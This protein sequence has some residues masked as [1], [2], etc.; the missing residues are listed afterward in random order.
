MLTIRCG[1]I[2]ER[3]LPISDYHRRELG[4]THVNHRLSTESAVGDSLFGVNRKSHEHA[5]LRGWIQPDT[6]EIAE[7]AQT[8]LVEELRRE[9][10]VVEEIQAG[11]MLHQ[12]ETPRHVDNAYK[13]VFREYLTKL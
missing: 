3:P 2:Q 11:V 12:R 4:G 10:P 5:Q 6:R 1:P 8:E 7:L 13:N 9:R